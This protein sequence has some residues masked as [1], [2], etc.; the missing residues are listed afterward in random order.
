MFCLL[1]Y[2]VHYLKGPQKEKIQTCN[3]NSKSA[4]KHIRQL[5]EFP[6]SDL[7]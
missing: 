1:F 2:R 3:P 5:F 6:K 4:M 7:V